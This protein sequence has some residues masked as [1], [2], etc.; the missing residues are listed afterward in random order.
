MQGLCRAWRMRLNSSSLQGVTEAVN[1]SFGGSV[2][3]QTPNYW[4]ERSVGAQTPNYWGEQI[5]K[6]GVCYDSLTKNAF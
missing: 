4:G 2:G 1:W 5:I 3:A 6:T